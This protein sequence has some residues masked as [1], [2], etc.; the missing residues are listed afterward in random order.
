MLFFMPYT[1]QR[2]DRWFTDPDQFQPERWTP[3]FE[4]SLP[5]GAYFP[6]GLGP[7]VCIGNGFAQ[8]E[9]Q[10]LL[11]TIMQRAEIHL[12]DQPQP[13]V[14]SPTISFAEP[15]PAQVRLHAR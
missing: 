12:L 9:A 14:G 7:R 8:M 4:K 11:A 2:D 10:L 1:T 5:K 15:V 13:G 6:F 3:E